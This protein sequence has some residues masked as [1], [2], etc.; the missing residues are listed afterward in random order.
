MPVTYINELWGKPLGL[1]KLEDIRCG[2]KECVELDIPPSHWKTGLYTLICVVDNGFFQ[3][4]VVVD[5]QYAWDK[6]NDPSDTGRDPH[7]WFLVLRKELD[8]AL[9]GQDREM[10]KE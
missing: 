5:S 4:A 2:L 10:W 7:W 3:A 8:A 1:Q 9:S 6:V